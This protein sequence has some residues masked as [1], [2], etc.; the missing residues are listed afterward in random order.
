MIQAT[1]IAS[2]RSQ[3]WYALRS[4]GIGASEAA[5]ACGLSRWSTA[6]DVWA[7][8]VGRSAKIENDAMALGTLMEPVVS[9]F[10]M[11]KTGREIAV[12]APGMYRHP[13][14]DCV[15]ASPDAILADGTLG[16]WKTTTSRNTD[17]GETGTD[18]V[19]IEWLCQAQQQMACTGAKAVRFGVLVDGR[20]F[21]EYLVERHQSLIDSIIERDVALWGHVASNN[22]PPVDWDHSRA[23]ES[24]R[25]AFA[26]VTNDD[27]VAL[28][29]S[30]IN[31]WSTYTELTA[32]IKDA[33]A[34]K[35][36]IAA[37]LMAEIKDS[38]GGVMPNGT[39]LKKVVVQDTVVPE[40]RRNGY[41][42]LRKGK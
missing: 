38:A 7:S 41:S 28:P 34:K 2:D 26:Q 14:V 30:A 10:F 1:P 11:R 23:T 9:A 16:E 12:E 32:T 18:E 15:L 5:A 35:K 6:L 42:F 27:Y 33:E 36:I 4:T 40:H 37:H 31:D 17:L 24:V 3:D 20:E 21:R 29:E 19:P 8:K 13:D 39:K 22:P 25:R